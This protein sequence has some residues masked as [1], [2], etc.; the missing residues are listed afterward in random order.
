MTLFR[1]FVCLAHKAVALMRL[2][3]Y[4]FLYS[5]Y[6]IY[7]YFYLYEGCGFCT[8]VHNPVIAAFVPCQAKCFH[9]SFDF[10]VF[11]GSL[12]VSVPSPILLFSRL[13]MYIQSSL[14]APQIIVDNILPHD[15]AIPPPM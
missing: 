3:K 2:K 15:F 13:D 9:F 7:A 12:L 6:Y 4:I 1:V 11:V 8:L 5:R 14:V 10:S